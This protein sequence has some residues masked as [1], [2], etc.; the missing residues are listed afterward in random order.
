MFDIFLGFLG[1]FMNNGSSAFAS[2][3]TSIKSL[4][5]NVFYIDRWIGDTTQM[6]FFSGM[7][8]VVFEMA[9]WLLILKFL[10]NGFETYISETG[11]DPD[12]SPMAMVA[13]FVKA[14][15]LAVSFPVLY[16]FFARICISFLMML[17]DSSSLPLSENSNLLTQ[18]TT[19]STSGLANFVFWI[20]FLILYFQLLKRGAELLVLRLCFPI[21]CVGLIESDNGAYAP[22]MMMIFKTG[23]TTVIQ[24]ALF[25]LSYKMIS[26]Y[27]ILIGFIFLI[28]AI[29]A[30]K[31]LQQ[32]M[33]PS[34][35]G[36]G[37]N[38]ALTVARISEVAV[39][40]IK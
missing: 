15:V 33:V 35:G 17:L 14:I 13:R 40:A 18:I 2:N 23:M 37:A 7:S 39:R 28:L 6:D 10:R 11:G 3:T 25:Q 34:G 22:F 36:G 9:M 32:F 20:G 26:S 31:F 5:D 1:D 19:A 12:A 29:T 21:A 8:T 16:E 30:P 24:I 4:A 27:D 38:K